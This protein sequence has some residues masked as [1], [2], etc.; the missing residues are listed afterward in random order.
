MRVKKCVKKRDLQCS[1]LFCTFVVVVVDTDVELA[2]SFLTLTS[3]T[4]R[5]FRNILYRKE[6]YFAPVVLTFA[7]ELVLPCGE[8]VWNTNPRVVP[9]AFGVLDVREDR[10]DSVVLLCFRNDPLND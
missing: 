2:H 3:P 8:T 4:A 9:D 1:V 7:F 10:R 5:Y 6:N